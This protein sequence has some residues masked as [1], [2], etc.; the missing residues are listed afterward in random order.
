[1][2]SSR[3]LISLLLI[4]LVLPLSLSARKEPNGWSTPAM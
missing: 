3:S 2:C 1:M 4:T